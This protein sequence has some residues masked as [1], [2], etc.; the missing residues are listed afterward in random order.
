MFKMTSICEREVTFFRSLL[1]LEILY[2]KIIVLA[3]G[4]RKRRNILK[5]YKRLQIF[6]DPRGCKTFAHK[7]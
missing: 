7:Y 3:Y 6:F 1:R 5:T 2:K 4:F